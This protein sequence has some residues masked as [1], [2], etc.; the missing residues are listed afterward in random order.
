MSC[1][2]LEKTNYQSSGMYHRFCRTMVHETL[3]FFLESQT[4]YLMVGHK[5]L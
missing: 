3:I 1:I 2:S 4:H 5:F